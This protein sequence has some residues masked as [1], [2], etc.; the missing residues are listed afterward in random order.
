MD[1]SFTLNTKDIGQ[2]DDL[3]T[4]LQQWFL[5]ISDN[6]SVPDWMLKMSKLTVIGQKQSERYT[7]IY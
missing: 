5:S 1:L 7:D 4:P 2:D 3:A 6:R